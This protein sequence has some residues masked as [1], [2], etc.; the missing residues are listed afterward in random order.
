MRPGRAQEYN[1][2]HLTVDNGLSNS[3]VTSICQD[4]R[5]FMW[6]GT[7]HGLNKYDGYHVTS[8]VA[9]PQDSLSLRD[10][11]ITCL[12]EDRQHT[13]WVGTNKGGLN[14]YDR[15]TDAVVG[16]AREHQKTH[17]LSA[18]KVECIFEDSRGNLWVGTNYGLNLFDRARNTTRMFYARPRDST[19]LN[20]NQVYAVLENDRREVLV[21]TDK[22]ALNKYDPR[23]GSFA[24]VPVGSRAA[25]LVTAR[26]LL[27]DR[28]QNYWV[29]TLEHGLLR[30]DGQGLRRYQHQA[31]QAASLGHDQ[32]RALLQTRQGA[33]WV[34]TDGG[35]VS[36]Y[37]PAHDNFAHL[38]ANDANAGSLSSNAVYS[39]YEDRSGA[40]W[41]GTF[42]GS[43]NYY[44]PHKAHFSH[45]SHLP[46]TDN[47]LGNRS[48]LALHQDAAGSIWLGTDGGGL[49][50]FDPR[51]KTFEH[52]RHDPANPASIASDVVKTVYEDRQG[53]LWLGTYLGGLDRYDPA[54]HRFIHY[55]TQPNQPTSLAN[56]IAWHLYEDHHNQLWVS[57]LRAG[58]CF[59]D[60]ATGKFTRFRPFSGPGSLGD[61]NIT[62]M[63][64]DAV[65][66]LWLG[67]E[68][69]G[70][71]LYHPQTRTF[72][73]LGH[74]AQQPNSLSSNRIQVLFNDSRGRLWVGT[75]DGGLNLMNQR[76]RTFQ[77]FTTQDG[78][79]SNV[80]NSIV[81]DRAG[82]LWLSTNKG[83]AR[84]EEKAARL[85]ISTRRMACRATS[86]TSTRGC[87]PATAPSTLA[88]S[89]GSTCLPRPTS[90][91][92]PW[93]RP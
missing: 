20:S 77:H 40:L 36:V 68:N 23:T 49:D 83:L 8:Y 17:P 65:G 19:A 2:S 7:F 48:V 1:F 42:G 70:L 29:G 74:E 55:T 72:S 75:A 37:D 45:Y 56:N 80:I 46:Q 53:T 14:R 89:T 27:Q 15:K 33:L 10:D 93:P 76:D 79:P 67:T 61:T 9:N 84:F 12:Y 28:H 3:S 71:Y 57:T 52:F 32:V 16:Y 85:R 62:T 51:R 50:R 87:W 31:A 13:L 11:Y 22:E 6:F 24:P 26:T 43:V 81:E 60:R 5:G 21:L 34:G 30:F 86:S 25:S 82:K 39:L 91:A 35:G 66:N 38:R 63:L 59:L 18:D 73:Y 92:T 4:S 64:E 88:A 58:V 78:L 41:V 44:N 90:C 69:Y 47:S 54:H